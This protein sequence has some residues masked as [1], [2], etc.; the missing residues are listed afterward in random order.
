MLA[1]YKT[2]IFVAIAAVPA[3]TELIHT[4]AAGG[5]LTTKWGALTTFVAAVGAIWARSVA[6]PA[7]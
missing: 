4:L 1:G 5:D 3:I 2:Y 6:K 7:A